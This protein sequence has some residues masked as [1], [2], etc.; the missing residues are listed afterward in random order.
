MVCAE[1]QLQYEFEA[2]S[3]GGIEDGSGFLFLHCLLLF[4][5]L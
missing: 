4:G 1:E 3:C 5:T 2:G